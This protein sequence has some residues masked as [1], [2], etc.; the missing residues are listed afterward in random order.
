V[1]RIG[2]NLCKFSPPVRKQRGPPLKDLIKTWETIIKNTE[3][4]PLRDSRQLWMRPGAKEGKSRK[5]LGI[6][7]WADMIERGT[8]PQTRNEKKKGGGT[9][10][11]SQA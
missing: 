3:D 6:I 9:K 1:A 8:R 7:E 10:D 2:S 5:L 4:K 11:K